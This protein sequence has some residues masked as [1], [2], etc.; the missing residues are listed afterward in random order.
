MWIFFVWG[1]SRSGVNQ[2]MQSCAVF[3]RLEEALLQEKRSVFFFFFFFFF[4]CCWNVLAGEKRRSDVDGAG[5]PHERQPWSIGRLVDGGVVRLAARTGGVGLGDLLVDRGDALLELV[6]LRLLGG[7]GAL[8]GA[9]LLL[10]LLLRLLL[11]QQLRVRLVLLRLDTLELLRQLVRRHPLAVGAHLEQRHLR[12]R[13]VHVLLQHLRVL[14][15]RAD[16][17][18]LAEDVVLHLVGAVLGLETLVLDA[19]L[20]TLPLRLVLRHELVRLLLLLLQLDQLV[21]LVLHVVLLLLQLAA[22]VVRLPLLLALR[23]LD[24]LVR[25]GRHVVRLLL[26]AAHRDVLAHQRVEQR[27]VALLQ[28][29]QLLA[30]GAGGT[31]GLRDLRT[32]PQTRLLEVV[33]VERELD[34]RRRTLLPRDVE[35]LV[36]GVDA[37]L[38]LA[39]LLLKGGDHLLA[40]LQ[41]LRESL[42]AGL[43]LVQ[44]VAHGTDLGVQGV[45]D[46]SGL[47]DVRP[48]NG[49]KLLGLLRPL[50]GPKRLLVVV[51]VRGHVRDHDR[52]GVATDRVLEQLRQDGVQ[53]R[54]VGQGSV[55]VAAALELGGV[56][57]EDLLLP[58]DEGVDD[59]TQGH[60]R[61]VDGGGLLHV[62]RASSTLGTGQVDQVHA[63]GARLPLRAVAG[64]LLHPL[65]HERDREDGVRT[66]RVVVH[67]GDGRRT[68]GGTAL[69]HLAAVVPRVHRHSLDALDER[70]QLGVPAHTRLLHGAERLLHL[71]S[72]TA[73]SARRHGTLGL[74][75]DAGV[76]KVTHLLQVDLDEGDSHLQLPALLLRLLLL[77]L[78][79]L[80]HLL[81]ELVAH[82]RD[83]ASVRRVTALAVPA[84]HRVGLSGGGLA[85]RQHTRVDAHERVVDHGDSDLV[86]GGNVVH[87][88]LADNV[89]RLVLVV[90]EVGRLLDTLLLLRGDR[91]QRPVEAELVRRLPVVVRVQREGR[92]ADH[93]DRRLQRLVANLGQLLRDEGP[94]TGEHTEGRDGGTPLDGKELILVLLAHLKVDLPELLEGRHCDVSGTNEVQIL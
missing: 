1:G 64:L 62:L 87:A 82:T 18:D 54:N 6:H 14:A 89:L 52:L 84:H 46:H 3:A 56:A 15:L 25:L 24:R 7:D 60:Q 51:P 21:A 5:G 49:D 13:H 88:L 92:V 36:E 72:A 91:P 83:D 61:L 34:D 42:H 66:R 12:P 73:V 23:V 10:S 94:Q 90:V 57:L 35:L 20:L 58:V 93:L 68:V 8:E 2:R 59:T 16:A 47:V 69:E 28:R 44:L 79:P 22:Q 26:D 48:H 78:A 29:L 27:L 43:L 67:G 32:A 17:Q 63:T 9:L 81:E 74:L 11:L 71:G 76:Q 4:F 65:L 50:E 40:V 77:V 85:V 41:L 45:L 39:V 86:R 30:R 75:L 38:G 37:S 19:G 53:V 80:L 55:A 33:Q 70:A 31:L